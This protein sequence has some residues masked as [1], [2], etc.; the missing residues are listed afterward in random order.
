M[1]EN[2]K[3]YRVLE[4]SGNCYC[5]INKY[6]STILTTRMVSKNV[7]YSCNNQSVKGENIKLLE[8]A[9]LLEHENCIPYCFLYTLDISFQ[10]LHHC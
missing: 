7:I 2:R 6:K 10:P 3:K 8:K 5:K 1:F 4:I 9:G